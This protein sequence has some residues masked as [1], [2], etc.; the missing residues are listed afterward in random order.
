MTSQAFGGGEHTP[1]PTDRIRKFVKLDNN[2]VIQES[3]GP[4]A[5]FS[6]ASIHPYLKKNKIN[7]DKTEGLAEIQTNLKKLKLYYSI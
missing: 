1:T 5:M 2:P 4:I 7:P 6:I 3:F